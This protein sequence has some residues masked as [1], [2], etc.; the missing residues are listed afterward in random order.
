MKRSTSF[1]A[2]SSASASASALALALTLIFLPTTTFTQ[3]WTFTTISN[4]GI[5]PVIA[6]DRQDRVHVVYMTEANPGWVRYALVENGEVETQEVSTGYFYGPPDITY[7]LDNNPV[8]AYHDHDNE[9]QAVRVLDEDEWE[10]FD[11]QHPGHDGWDNSIAVDING[12]IHTSSVDPSS[13]GGQGIEYAVYE[14][15]EWEVEGVGS[16]SIMYANATSI[17]LNSFNEVFIS[18]YDDE[19]G[20]LEMASNET[21]SWVITEVDTTSDSGRF[22]SLY[23]DDE[24]NLYISYHADGD[25]VK[26]ASRVNG[27]W[28]TQIIDRLN[29]FEIG[30]NGARNA[31][32]LSGFEDELGLA[33]GDKDLVKFARL[34]LEGLN[35]LDIDTV[36]MKSLDDLGQIVSLDYSS[37]GDAYIAF[38]VNSPDGDNYG[39]IFLAKR[40]S[41][42]AVPEEEPAYF[43]ITP[44]I[45]KAG[46]IITLDGLSNRLTYKLFSLQGTVIQHGTISADSRLEIDQ[47]INSGLY[48]ISIYS[49]EGRLLSTSRIVIY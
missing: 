21:G 40:N 15:G 9:D 8:I 43:K 3:T 38:A 23:I 7:N 27:T 30:F 41:S 32:G 6:I 47:H 22:S 31:T 5:K 29:N 19:E 42:T 10:N 25:F 13:F 34:S 12:M 18:Y 45:L 26:L 16:G 49:D 35:V 2:L 11:T 33:Y 14:G 17:A 20:V 37:T 28:S 36:V 44:N 4:D 46:Q 1:S 39:N 24:D 48:F